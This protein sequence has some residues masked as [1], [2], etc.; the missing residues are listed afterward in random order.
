[1]F[2]YNL[3][4]AG[5]GRWPAYAEYAADRRQVVGGPQLEAEKQAFAENFVKR[6]EFITRYQS[7]TTAESFV[8]ALLASAP[9][10]GSGLSEQRI[11][12]ISTYSS[13]GSMELSRALVLRAIA[14]NAEF[15]QAQYNGAF[16]LTEYFS[17]LRR[18]PD[19]EGYNFWFNALNNS[20]AGD[21]GNYHGM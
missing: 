1:M 10:Y 12:L 13:G 21:R 6:A 15:I 11:G 5:L 2:I 14:D 19:R 17:Y 4:E 7:N 8:D 20:G 16:V 9:V 18:D 3:Y